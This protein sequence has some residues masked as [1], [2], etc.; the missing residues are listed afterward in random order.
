MKINLDKV[1]NEYKQ[2]ILEAI[3]TME[4]E[5]PVIKKM[6]RN[7]AVKPLATE[8]QYCFATTKLIFGRKLQFDIKLNPKAFSRGNIYEKFLY[9]FN[10]FYYSPKDIIY[11]EIAHVLQTF[12]I[13]EKLNIQIKSGFIYW[14]IN[15]YKFNYN[16]QQKILHSFINEV[17]SKYHFQGDIIVQIL[18]SYAQCNVL[19]VVPESYN[20][21]YRLKSKYPNLT[22][23]E[24][25]IYKFT[26]VIINELNRYIPKTAYE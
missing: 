22:S 9:T 19:E 6:I 10:A 23:K 3:Y 14:S 1:L 20:N 11:H 4:K 21:Y 7:I 24:H 18:G 5:Y 15:K 2:D 12:L 25:D 17:F 8:F 13:C 16:S 26:R